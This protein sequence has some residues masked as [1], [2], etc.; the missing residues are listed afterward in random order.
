MMYSNV[1]QRALMPYLVVALLL[2]ALA[3][4]PGCGRGESPEPDKLQP[5]PHAS[6]SDQMGLY[7]EELVMPLRVE[8]LGPQEPGLL[9]GKGERHAVRNEPVRFEIV[10]KESGAE[11]VESGGRVLEVTTDAGGRASARVRLGDRPGDIIVL[12]RL[13]EHPDVEPVRMRVGAGITRIGENL[14]G[15]TGGSVREFGVQLTNPDG[16]PAEGV[17]V[18]FRVEGNGHGASV[19]H[20]RLVTDQ[21]GKAITSWKL[22]DKVQQ[23]FATAEIKDTRPGVPPEERFH[24]RAI[25]FEA[26]ATNFWQM[27]L[28][29]FGGLAVFILGMRTMS[30]GLQKVADRRLKQ[31]LH[32]MTQNRFMAVFAG[33]IITAMVQ[34]SSATTVMTVGFVNAGLMQLTQAIGVVFGANIGTT[35][36]AQIIAFKLNALS[37]PAIA[38]GLALLMF[39]RT[40]RWKFIGQSVMGFGLI[41]L[42]MMTMSGILKPLRHSPEFVSWFQLFDCTPEPGGLV[43]ALPALMCVLIGTGTTVVVQSSSA[44]VGL[45]LALASQGLISFYTAVPLILGDNIGTTITANLAAIGAN[46]NA[47]RAAIAHTLF[48][49][50]GAAYMYLLLFVPLWNG[51]PFFLGLVDAFT[52]GDVFGDRPE[53]LLRHVA[54]AHS[55][56]NIFN[57]LLFL[58]FTNTIG[59]VCRFLVPVTEAD[60]TTA[61]Q[62]LEPKLLQTPSIALEQAVREITYMIRQGRKSTN[63]SCALF[64]RRNGATETKIVEREA[65]I[66][67]LQ[68]DIAE[69]LVALSRTSLNTEEASLMPDLLHAV[70]DAERLGDHA[71]EMLE[72]YHLLHEYDLKLS[73]AELQE[74]EDLRQLLDAQFAHLFQIL[75]DG[76]PEVL[77]EVRELHDELRARIKSYTDAN[78]QRIDDGVCDVQAGVVYMD[79]LTHL[80][81]LGEHLL[82]IAERAIRMVTV[83]KV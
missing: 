16:T 36:T 8:V 57:C 30:E 29:L 68:H 77:P 5:D 20:A 22:G 61:L 82:N 23:Y 19:K 52:A 10:D 73:P 33:F 74:I 49:V 12:A 9:G 58:P 44:T 28:V 41:F 38:V 71:E 46:R 18:F 72:L 65:L 69:Y 78:V 40:P 42:G 6:G 56:F 75:D 76:N 45:V 54:N 3:V 15:K 51:E 4:F 17:E 2:A 50:F 27:L 24:V 31:V 60:R 83:L 14:E 11:F 66:D 59:R 7:D 63:E 62:Y 25:E 13:P 32:F 34:S 35:V 53:N 70:N 79:A 80:E 21:E 64:Q 43:P 39:A 1:I 81:R 67:Q 47:R 26:M 37:Y 55:A 48:N